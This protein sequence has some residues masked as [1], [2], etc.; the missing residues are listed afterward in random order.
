MRSRT[1]RMVPSRRAASAISCVWWRAWAAAIMC[2]RRSSIHFT[3]RFSA[4][5]GERD[6]HVLGI[7]GGLGAEAAAE[8]G[9]DHADLVRRQ[10]ERGGQALLRRSARPG[11]CSRW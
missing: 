9:R 10:L 4:H 5:G 7:A 3:G 6:Q 1:P 2:S 11:C 8:V